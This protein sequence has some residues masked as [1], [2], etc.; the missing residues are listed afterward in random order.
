MDEA[1]SPG[2]PPAANAL[3]ARD[4]AAALAAAGE[5]ADLARE[6]FATLM[7]GL[8]REISQLQACFAAANW[9][10]LV[11]L[12]HR[13]RGATGYCGV[14]RLDYGLQ[15]LERAAKAGETAAISVWLR[16][17][18]DAADGLYEIAGSSR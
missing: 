18:T 13:L 5:D 15:E 4:E 3:P 17:V 1:Y 8:P 14:P 16:A 7:D 2:S 10:E 11:G 12:A 6:L 9:R